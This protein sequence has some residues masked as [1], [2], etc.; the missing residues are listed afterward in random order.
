ML[1]SRRRLGGSTAQHARSERDTATGRLLRAFHEDGDTRAR[2]RLIQLYLPLVE[3]FAN[4]YSRGDVEHDD[5]VQAGSI[6]LLNAIQRYD[7]R[8][9]E[10][11]TAFA[12]PTI[13]GEIKRHIRDR[14][15][16][17]KLPRSLQETAARLP[18][19]RE[20]LTARLGRMPTSS[21]LAAS[22]DVTLDD[23]AR[24]EA[25][26][27]AHVLDD[28]AALTDADDGKGALDLSE[29]RLQLA[30]AFRAL[31][32]TEQRIVYLR[33]VKDRSRK[34]TADELGISE[35]QLTRRTHAAL[36][37]LRG[38]LERAASGQRAQAPDDEAQRGARAVERQSAEKATQTASEEHPK[39]GSEERPKDGYSGRLLLRMPQS[40][41][42]ELAE[43]AEREE[44]SLN[45]F[46]TNTLAA[47]TRWHRPDGQ[48]DEADEEPRTSPRWL[49][50]AIVT[51]IV[52]VAI[53]G[54]VALVLL[55]VAWQQGW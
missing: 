49:P 3:T 37:K 9:G 17:V 16:P 29:E 6:G 54:I 47:A 20:E 31:D 38:E 34:Q 25:A 2:D 13:V 52:V 36:A 44:V 42:A 30:G 27:Q 8:R 50:A 5:L 55:V 53:A 45:Q 28:T 7:R 11:F 48:A 19:V 43:A 46:I 24:I 23:L 10:E 1:I 51:N 40:L 33:F 22:L 12:V 21:E 32:S 15:V 41:H 26:Q 4:R 39:D 35:G 14:A 18:R